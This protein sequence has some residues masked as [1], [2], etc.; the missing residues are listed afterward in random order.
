VW[1]LQELE[2]VGVRGGGWTEKNR[3]GLSPAMALAQVHRTYAHQ[4]LASY[5]YFVYGEDDVLLSQEAFALFALHQEELWRSGWT[6]CFFRT[7]GNPTRITDSLSLLLQK[8]SPV[9]L[10]P[11]SGASFV[12]LRQPYHALWALGTPQLAHFAR[13]AVYREGAE[14]FGLRERYAIGPHFV[15]HGG[16]QLNRC[17]TP[18]HANGSLDMRA[19]LPH[20]PNNYVQEAPLMEGF[21]QWDGAA[22]PQG[23]AL[24]LPLHASC[25]SS[26]AA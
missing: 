22:G 13:D 10:A 18:L 26:S 21:L 25:P 3:L 5:D 19:A 1:S 17:L 14:Q 15:R 20:L 23:H 11:H 9:Y 24:P 12:Q 7:E 4:R 8:N 6:Y 16:S 2:E